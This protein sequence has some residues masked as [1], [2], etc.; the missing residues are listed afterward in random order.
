MEYLLDRHLLYPHKESL[1][2]IFK[3]KKKTSKKAFSVKSINS[4]LDNYQLWTARSCYGSMM[5][6]FKNGFQDVQCFIV[7]WTLAECNSCIP[8]CIF[9]TSA[10]KCSTRQCST[11]AKHL[12]IDLMTIVKHY[13]TLKL[14]H[15]ERNIPWRSTSVF[16]MSN[17]QAVQSD[18][19][20]ANSMPYPLNRYPHIQP[21]CNNRHIMQD[22]SAWLKI[23]LRKEVV[24]S[25]YFHLQ[26]CINAFVR[27]MWVI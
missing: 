9:Y 2:T 27:R 25:P 26:P 17:S 22:W 10:P 4:N 21:K 5:F 24:L 8:K 18:A 19:S 3:K 7:Y 15:T 16:L 20:P 23:S 14:A 13:W 12:I 6:P 1:C 11:Q